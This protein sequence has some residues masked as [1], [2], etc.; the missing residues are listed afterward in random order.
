[1][2][3]EHLVMSL[4]VLIMQISPTNPQWVIDAKETL[5]YRSVRPTALC[6]HDAHAHV[7]IYIVIHSDVPDGNSC[8]R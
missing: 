3:I 4:R 1:M 8:V 2:L 7:V 6:T 5:I